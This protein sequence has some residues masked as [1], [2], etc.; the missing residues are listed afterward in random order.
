MDEPDPAQSALSYR[1]IIERETAEGPPS[2]NRRTTRPLCKFYAAGFCRFGEDCKL[3]HGDGSP[4]DI[5]V[6]ED[7]KVARIEAPAAVQ[8]AEESLEENAEESASI[9]AACGICMDNVREKS[10]RFGLLENCP[11]AF[12]LKCI[13]EWRSNASGDFERTNV[14]RCPLCRVTSYI[15]VPSRRLV[16]DP[17]RKATIFRTYR[18]NLSTIPCRYPAGSC[19]FGE[20]CLYFHAGTGVPE[21]QQRVFTT[22]TDGRVGERMPTIADYLA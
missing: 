21:A 8:S 20:S 1:K 10:G 4:S 9:S 13:R 19:P 17:K 18:E 7:E 15:I 2:G 22:A 5:I 3:S 14:R 11:H 12:C 16:T 6:G